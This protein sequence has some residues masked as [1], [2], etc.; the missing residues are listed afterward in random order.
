MTPPLKLKSRLNLPIN[1]LLLQEPRVGLSGRQA[2]RVGQLQHEQ[3]PRDPAPV[4]MGNDV[5][6]RAVGE[7]RRVRWTRQHMLHLQVFLLATLK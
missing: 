4:F 3:G 5:R 7:L 2:D 6:L 1:P